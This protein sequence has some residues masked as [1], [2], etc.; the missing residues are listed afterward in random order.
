MPPLSVRLPSSLA[1]ISTLY[2]A[3]AS[4]LSMYQQ[5]SLPSFSHS[6]NPFPKYSYR[7][8]SP[9]PLNPIMPSIPTVFIPR[10][11]S[12]KSPATK[13]YEEKQRADAEK[14]A[15][16]EPGLRSSSKSE[17]DNSCQISESER[18]TRE[19]KRLRDLFGDLIR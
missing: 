7:P 8:A 1:L 11:T 16:R 10:E 6:L 12:W 18:M 5:I 14:K 2:N 17:S 3:S 9:G 4:S 15:N 13:R 19:E